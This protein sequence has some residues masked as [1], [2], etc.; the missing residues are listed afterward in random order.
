MGH[1]VEKVKAR[2]KNKLAVE[3]GPLLITHWGLSGPAVLK[4]SA[5]AQG[6]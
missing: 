6:N 4:M 3:E 2:I 5:W 1:S